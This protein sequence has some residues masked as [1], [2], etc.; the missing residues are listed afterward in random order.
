MYSVQCYRE[1][2]DTQRKNLRVFFLFLYVC[3]QS[4]T[5]CLYSSEQVKTV[6]MYIKVSPNKITLDDLT[7]LLVTRLYSECNF[8]VFNPFFK[9]LIESTS[10][11]DVK[12]RQDILITCTLHYL[13]NEIIQF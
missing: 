4:G 11:Q 9:S 1:H 2:V 5:K 10:S 3:N 7:I 8:C 6:I 13:I 12:N